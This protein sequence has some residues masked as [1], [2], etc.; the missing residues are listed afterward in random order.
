MADAVLANFKLQAVPCTWVPSVQMHGDLV[1]SGAQTS[2]RVSVARCVGSALV[3]TAHVSVL[4]QNNLTTVRGVTRS[5]TESS[6]LSYAIVSFGPSDGVCVP[7][8]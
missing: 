8:S 7:M 3:D 5:A 2:A 6:E 1:A 4:L